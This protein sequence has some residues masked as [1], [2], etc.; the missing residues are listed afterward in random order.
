[1]G[2][3]SIYLGFLVPKLPSPAGDDILV[4]VLETID[5]DSFRVEKRTAMRIALAD[6]E[7]KIDV[8]DEGAKPGQSYTDSAE[9]REARRRIPASRA[10]GRGRPSGCGVPSACEPAGNEHSADG[11]E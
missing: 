6:D 11:Q 9:L 1:M 2:K 8:V 5:L 10:G 7:A 4:D 3:L